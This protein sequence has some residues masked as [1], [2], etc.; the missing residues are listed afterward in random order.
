MSKSES[1]ILL[2]YCDSFKEIFE[3]GNQK[4]IEIRNFGIFKVLNTKK[5]MQEISYK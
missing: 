4:R 3:D 5:K 2:D 1:I